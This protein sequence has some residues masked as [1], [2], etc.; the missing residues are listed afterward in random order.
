MGDR[1]TAPRRFR[2]MLESGETFVQP[3]A[4]NAQSAKIVERAGFKTVCVSGYGVSATLLGKPDVGLLTMTEVVQVTGHICDTVSIPV[5]ADSEAGFGNAI[6]AM[7]AVEELIKVG[8]A[9]VFMEDQV[10]PK[11]C[12]HV[13]GKQVVALDEAAGKFRAAVRARDQMDKEVIVVARCDARG[14]SG[15][16]IEEVVRRG[17]AYMDAG[18]DVFFPEGVLSLA[19]LE[20]VAREVK[21]PLVYNRTGIS[22]DLTLDDLDGLGVFLVMN[23]NGAMRAAARAMWNYLH[24]FARDDVR[25]D[26]R[27][28]AEIKDHPLADFHKFVGFEEMRR[29]EEVFLPADEVARKYDASLGFRP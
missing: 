2:D 24:D 14:V 10:A 26:I 3:G 23:P 25:L 11:R 22:P 20:Q 9:G 7:R 12:G 18:A 21:A 17:K 5:L 16:S 8:V 28:R 13:A 29:L 6:N 19:E 1:K 4:F 27:T 15:G